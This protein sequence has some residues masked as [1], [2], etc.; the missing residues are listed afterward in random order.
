MSSNTSIG[1]LARL[2]VR[3]HSRRDDDRV[4][5]QLPRPAQRHRGLDAVRLRLVARCQHDPGTH[6]HRAAAELPRRRAARRRRRTRRGPRGG[7]RLQANGCSHNSQS[8]DWKLGAER[9]VPRLDR[10]PLAAAAG[11]AGGRNVC[12]ASSRRRSSRSKSW[13][14][15]A[16]AARPV[17]AGGGRPGRASRANASSAARAGGR[18][19]SAR[20]SRARRA[21]A[22]AP[23]RRGTRPERGRGAVRVAELG[24]GGGDLRIGVPTAAAEHRRAQSGLGEPPPF[25][26]NSL[27]RRSPLRTCPPR[28]AP[29]GVV[30]EWAAGGCLRARSSHGSVRFT[31]SSGGRSKAAIAAA[32]PSAAGERRVPDAIVEDPLDVAGDDGIPF[33]EHGRAGP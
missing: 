27:S 16:R 22:A 13:K 18:P 26:Q 29:V 10:G 14:Y 21:R 4:R 12:S 8:A 5:A 24:D 31:A 17:R 6:E 15:T 33:A 3:G 19:R 2:G 1:G 7:S 11:R 25:A 32:R 20:A 9:A 23:R 28:A 30:A